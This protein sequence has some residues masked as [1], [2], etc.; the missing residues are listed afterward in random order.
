MRL[1][2][3][4]VIVDIW[5]LVDDISRNDNSNYALKHF[6]E[7]VEFYREEELDIIEKEISLGSDAKEIVKETLNIN[8][9]EW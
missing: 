3:K 6:N 8:M 7:R 2:A 1:H 4:K 9:N 5:D